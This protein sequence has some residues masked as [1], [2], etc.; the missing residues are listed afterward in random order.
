NDTAEPFTL[1]F[2]VSSGFF[3]EGAS[4]DAV[5][6]HAGKTG[7]YVGY[8]DLPAVATD[9]GSTASDQTAAPESSPAF[10]QS[11]FVAV[12]GV[13]LNR[14]LS[15]C[16][17][18]T[19]T[20]KGETKTISFLVLPGEIG[21]AFG[22][23]IDGMEGKVRQT[24]HEGNNI[25]AITDGF[26]VVCSTTMALQ[27]KVFEGYK[28]L[29]ATSFGWD[30]QHLFGQAGDVQGGFLQQAMGDWAMAAV[31]WKN[32]HN[33]QWLDAQKIAPS[34]PAAPAPVVTAPSGKPVRFA[35]PGPLIFA[36]GETVFGAFIKVDG[37]PNPVGM[38]FYASAPNSG[39]VSGGV[40]GRM[41]DPREIQR[42]RL[43]SCG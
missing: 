6:N 33:Q 21:L 15:Q 42:D 26:V 12:G 16:R 34:A 9:A 40:I 36:K 29:E 39:S 37:A 25:V 17:W 14:D 43:V 27:P 7:R 23:A 35:D 38:C 24:F 13:M 2:E 4:L 19:E 10:T 5:V 8:L 11:Q 41:P 28:L 31:L 22:W 3:C 18:G 1:G 30:G 20:Q 32:A